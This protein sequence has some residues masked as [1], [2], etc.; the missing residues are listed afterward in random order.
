MIERAMLWVNRPKLFSVR[1][2]GLGVLARQLLTLERVGVRKVWIGARNPGEEALKSL[3]LPASMEL[4]WAAALEAAKDC[5]APYLGLSGDHFIRTET[6]E[7]IV[8]TPYG[9]SVSFMDD[10]EASVAQIVLKNDKDFISYE[11][12]ALPAGASIFLE[13][14]LARGAVMDWLM[15][16]GPKGQDGFMARHFDRHISLAVSRKLVDTP[17]T[18]NL[19][20]A[21]SCLIGLA[22]AAFFLKPRPFMNF[23]G[24]FLIWLHSVLDGCDGELARIRFQESRWGGALDFWGDNLVHLALFGAI[25]A[26]LYQATGQFLC[27]VLGA[28]AGAGILGS[29]LMVFRDKTIR[30]PSRDFI[31]I[32]LF[33]AYWN[34]TY[35]FLWAGAVGAPLFLLLLASKR[36]PSPLEKPS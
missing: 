34:L 22:G 7:Y 18:P 11:K 8:K 12:Q 2:G 32:L 26:G 31:Y 9:V 21:L 25:A 17:I 14:P 1:T 36:N 24:A 19:M 20:T 3:R 27:L 29:A 13:E 16:I 23:A 30:P 35:Y 5:P 6:L 4:H 10:K 15:A 33:T 28:S